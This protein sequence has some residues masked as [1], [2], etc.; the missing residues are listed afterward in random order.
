MKFKKVF[1]I[2]LGLTGLFQFSS[3]TFGFALLGPFASWMEKT[4]GLRQPGDI[5]G[6]M[7]ITNGYRWNVPV[8]TYSFDQ[9]F[10]D[11]FGSNGVAAV[12]DAIQIL[13]DLPPASQ[14]LL[15]NY[16]LDSQQINYAAQAQ[17]LYDL[18][19]AT[20]VAL[21][22]QLGLTQP[23]RYIFVLRQWDPVFINHGG[24]GEWP[25]GIIPTNIVMRNFDPETLTPSQYVNG[26][27]FAGVVLSGFQV[28]EGKINLA[29]ATP[30]DPLAANASAVADGSI[31]NQLFISP[32]TLNPGEFFTTLTE[33]DIGG[34]RYLVST[35]NVNFETLLP[36]V[37]GF[38][39]NANTFV[40]GAWRPGI[41]KITFIPEPID[42]LN[43]EFFSAITNQFT[44]TYIT[45]GTIMQ[46]QVARVI[47]RP[48]FLFCAGDVNDGLQG[49]PFMDRT[50]TTNWVNNAALN[51]NPANGGP[52]V[53]QPPVRIT[54]NKLGLGFV[55]YSFDSDE[56]AESYPISWSTFDNSTNPP[57]VYPISQTGDNQ[58]TIRMWLVM[59]SVGNQFRRNFDWLFNS[60]AGVQFALQTSTNLTD[61][62]SIFTVMNNGTVC[63][64]IN[65]NP[66]SVNRFY[67]VV[68]Q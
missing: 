59:D 8:V 45:N 15:T 47:A 46:Q 5:G 60:P 9:S 43:G 54:F 42:P 20:L 4:N 21:L 26:A 41:D 29:L 57:V 62:V 30:V 67:R 31:N 40:N 12:K 25:P 27:L 34:L 53:I 17:N 51:G 32:G 68:P 66:S 2:L 63:T 61:W 3:S 23:T 37:S 50:G 55:K 7:D 36:T 10:L 35:N 22:E 28:L 11:F 64:Y 58:L 18:K 56:T 44:D 14:M 52:G 48:D 6:P 19:S 65:V 13:N 33:D 16:P 38:G 49:I 39:T 24:Q 1:A